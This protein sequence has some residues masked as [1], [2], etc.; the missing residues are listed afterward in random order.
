MF[1][2]KKTPYVVES[3]EEWNYISKHSINYWTAPY[4]QEFY[5]PSLN[6]SGLPGDFLHV[7][8]IDWK[9][10]IEVYFFGLKNQSESVNTVASK[11]SAG[12]NT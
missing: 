8:K 12:T 2:W 7:N 3:S 10:N 9:R 4:R 1:T 5:N 11:V 6:T